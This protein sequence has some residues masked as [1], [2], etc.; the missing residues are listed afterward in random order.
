MC[1]IVLLSGP[2]A[3]AR[4]PTC[5]DRLHHRG[6]DD[7]GTWRDGEIALGFTRLRINGHGSVGA[8]PIC[9]SG[10][11]AAINGEIYNHARLADAYGLPGSECD[12][13]VVLPLLARIG[14]HAID[15]LDGFYSAVV[16]QPSN[17]QV[18][19]L[20]DN[21]GKKP[22]F[23]GSSEGDLFITSEMKAVDRCDWFQMLPR[24]ASTV[25][26]DTGAVSLQATHRH[27]DCDVDL[28]TAFAQAVRKRMPS[29]D[30]PVGLFLSG[31]L[32]S[33]LVASFASSLRED[34]TYFTLGRPDHPDFQAA[35]T[36]V[37]A[38]RLR[39]VRMVAL[40]EPESIPL[41]LRQ[42]VRATESFNPS[43][44]SNGLATFL[45]AKA[46]REA[47]IKVVLTG[48]GADELF[49]GYH[50]FQESDPWR[51]T[52]EQLIDQMQFTELRRLDL[53]CMAQSVEPRC[54]FLDRAVRS[55]SDG[56]GYRDFFD[57]GVNKAV[58]RRTFAGALP[59]AIIHRRKTSFDIGSGIRG[60]VVRYLR[61]SGRGERE[62]LR[63]I[64]E[65]LFLHKSSDPYFHAYPAFDDAIDRRGESHR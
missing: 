48:E 4:L 22:L 26:L 39:D 57:A 23:V 28:A 21:M 60:L 27:V 64:W 33:S 44:V 20:R 31:G 9:D 55:I 62:E 2:N 53:C 59:D 61:R 7:R 65:E 38:L 6:P 52:R 10:L 8:Q 63:G 19:C 25:D 34:A 42:V 15:D 43:I 30:Q 17:R 47:G 1:G 11:I 41:L 46:A 58:L 29:V 16:V 50:S 32:D 54:P 14:L 18:L 12:T 24:G 40:P 35:K 49:G 36:V 37:D 45:L 5:L 3:T 13:S 56:L 51:Q